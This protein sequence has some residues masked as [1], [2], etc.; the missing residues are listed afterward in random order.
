MVEICPDTIVAM[1][2][3]FP[4]FFA[5]NITQDAMNNNIHNAMR[6]ESTSSTGSYRSNGAG[7]L[8]SPTSQSNTPLVIPQPVKPP[9]TNNKNK[10]YQCKMCDQVSLRL[11]CWVII[12]ADGHF[13]IVV[14]LF[15]ENRLWYF[16]QIVSGDNLLEM[17]VCFLGK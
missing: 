13:E 15:P 10:T 1:Y 11:V 16:M 14:L 7:S 5:G 9:P 4:F 6:H 2:Y 12:S 8:H 3:H 17:S